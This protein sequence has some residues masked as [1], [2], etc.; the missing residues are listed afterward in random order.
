[1]FFYKLKKEINK[2]RKR[3][4]MG[5]VRKIKSGKMP[6]LKHKTNEMK[7]IESFER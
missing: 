4:K 1:M 7:E 2:I 3:R 5:K 6:L